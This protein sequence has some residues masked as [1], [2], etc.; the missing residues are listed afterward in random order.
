MSRFETSTTHGHSTINDRRVIDYA[1]LSW[2][3]PYLSLVTLFLPWAFPD[4]GFG[5][6]RK[7]H[8]PPPIVL[9]WL[10]TSGSHSHH[11]TTTQNAG[12][13]DG[14]PNITRPRASKD[15]SW[16]SFHKPFTS[17]PSKTDKAPY[18]SPSL[19]TLS[20]PILPLHDRKSGI[21]VKTVPRR[22]I[23]SSRNPRQLSLSGC[24]G[25]CQ[26]SHFPRIQSP[27]PPSNHPH[28]AH[29]NQISSPPSAPLASTCVRCPGDY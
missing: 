27:Q 12:H 14:T 17:L 11:E 6:Q 24:Q 5:Y 21:S 20:F 16:V 13:L 7:L 19:T 3:S 15:P 4:A 10:C 8:A 25:P 26:D 29:H 9:S 2:Q 28:Q 18:Q 22:D 23:R 1:S